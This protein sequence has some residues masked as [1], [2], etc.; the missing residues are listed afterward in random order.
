MHTAQF[1]LPLV[2]IQHMHVAWAAVASATC[3]YCRSEGAPHAECVNNV[4][5]SIRAMTHC[6]LPLLRSF[7]QPWEGVICLH[8]H[9]WR[10]DLWSVPSDPTIQGWVVTAKVWS[11]Q[12]TAT[13]RKVCCL[14]SSS[15]Q[16][17]GPVTGSLQTWRIQSPQAGQATPP[18][19]QR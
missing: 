7:I 17:E 6:C 1:G 4:A 3:E 11:R 14:L 12:S 9:Y 18:D 19:C 15:C 10:L 8:C 2:Q 16:L 13:D 5:Q